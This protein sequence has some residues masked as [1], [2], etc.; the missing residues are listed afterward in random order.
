MGQ[1]N[2]KPVES[3]MEKHREGLEAKVLQLVLKSSIMMAA[4]EAK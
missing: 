2:Q 1:I 3:L 4:S